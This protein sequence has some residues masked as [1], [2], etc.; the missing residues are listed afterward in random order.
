SEQDDE[1]GHSPKPNPAS[2]AE[3]VDG[4]T[5]TCAIERS[6]AHQ[7][8]TACRDDGADSR[9]SGVSV[10]EARPL[11]GFAA[12]CGEACRRPRI[13]GEVLLRGQDQAV[14]DGVRSP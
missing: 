8:G 9:R 7:G 12:G 11:W 3:S 13:A 2:V 4:E 1:T 6:P 14:R 5:Q 10:L